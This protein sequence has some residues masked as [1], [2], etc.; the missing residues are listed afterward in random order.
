MRVQ[1][2]RKVTRLRL[3]TCGPRDRLKD[4]ATLL[5][6]ERI[7]ALPVVDRDGMMVGIIS[8]RDICHALADYAERTATL[9]V[10]QIMTRDVAVC[11]PSDSVQ[12]AIA[13]MSQRRIRHLPLVED[14]QLVGMI[15]LRDVLEATLREV[16][17]EANVLRDYARA[18]AY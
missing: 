2:L 10:D 8:E 15:S 4:V 6:D 3:V 5:S 14:G 17:L 1:E 16:R 13:R 12:D 18:R 7:G 9:T 11:E